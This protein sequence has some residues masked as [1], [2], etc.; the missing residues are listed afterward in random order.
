YD[1]WSGLMRVEQ[2]H[3]E[4]LQMLAEG[5]LVAIGCV[6]LFIFLLFKKGLQV[7][8]STKGFRQSA[9]IGALAGCLGIMV[10]SFFD[11]P[12]R[13]NSNMFVFLLMAAIATVIVT[14]GENHH[15]RHR[16]H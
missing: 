3:N 10:H 8:S 12:L 2:A 6:L 15:R 1:T 7:V 4:Y 13:T 16:R 5:G 9:A 11:F 14:V